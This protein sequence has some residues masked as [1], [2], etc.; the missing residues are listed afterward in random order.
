MRLATAQAVDRQT[1]RLSCEE[2]EARANAS[3]V[4]KP[5]PLSN[6]TRRRC[7]ACESELIV[8]AGADARKQAEFLSAHGWAGDFCSARCSLLAGKSAA[9]QVPPPPQTRAQSDAEALAHA[10]RLRQA[11]GLP[12]PDRTPPTPAP[13]RARA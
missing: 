9:R 5:H 3:Y 2:V 10:D 7:L 12:V 1:G 11:Y 4:E 13:K 6:V 8:P